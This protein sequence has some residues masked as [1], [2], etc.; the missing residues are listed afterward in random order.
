MR[1]K[2]SIL[3]GL[4]AGSVMAGLSRGMSPDDRKS[5]QQM[6]LLNLPSVPSFDAWILKTG[7]LPPDFDA[8]SRQNG[9]PDP[10]TFLGGKPVKSAADW[11][12]R[13]GEIL[14]LYEKWVWGKVPP[15]P[16]FDHAVVKDVAGAGYRTRTGILFCG[17]EGQGT[18]RI[19]MQ[20]PDGVGP[21]GGFPVVMGPGLVGEPEPVSRDV[22]DAHSTPSVPFRSISSQSDARVL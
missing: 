18:I 22:I 11:P 9:L 2:H 12:A 10:L 6:L 5:Y 3:L 4:V 15:H 14:G 16:A 8:L 21:G 20:I 1:L 19:T 7:E 13:R 17:P